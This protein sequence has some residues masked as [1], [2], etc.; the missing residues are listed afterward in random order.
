[1]SS[2]MLADP[3][4]E[5]ILLPATTRY[6]QPGGGTETTTER[7]IAFSPEISGPRIGEARAEWMTLMDL[8]RRIHPDRANLIEFAD[9]QAVRDEI[10]RVVPFYEGIQHLRETGDQVQWGGAR[11]CDGWTFPTADG[12]ARFT[13]VAPPE[14]DVPEGRFLLSTRRGKQF[15]TIVHKDRDPLTGAKRD[16]V[17]VSA[18]DA[19]RLGLAEDQV[20]TLTSEHGDMRA[21]VKVAAIKPGNL[22]VFYPEGNSLL[23]T[24]RYDPEC[25]IPDYTAIVQLTPGP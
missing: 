10:A 16:H 21:R 25:K 22:Q 5:V 20:V 12:K 15:N 3:G 1:V 19:S 9:A 24:G 13:P 8:A 11:L 6:E 23:G 4:E 2:Q 14:L 7:R 17:F 18:D